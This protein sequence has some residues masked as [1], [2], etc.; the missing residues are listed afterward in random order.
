MAYE[1]AILLEFFHKISFVQHDVREYHLL[2][3]VI[4]R[5][6]KTYPKVYKY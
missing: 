6:L 1:A 2:K 5:Y 3:N 4:K